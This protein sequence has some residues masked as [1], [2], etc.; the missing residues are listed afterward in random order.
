MH[1]RCVSSYFNDI[2]SKASDEE[3]LQFELTDASSPIVVRY[4]ADSVVGDYRN[5]KKADDNGT[6]ERYS[7]FFALA[8]P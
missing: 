8:K 2:V 6:S 7:V 5:F 1:V 4:Y 3:N